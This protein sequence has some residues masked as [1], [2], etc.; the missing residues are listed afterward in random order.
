MALTRAEICERFR[1]RH[2]EKYTAEARRE[3]RKRYEA[4][5][6]ATPG[7]KK[8]REKYIASGKKALSDANSSLFYRFG[9]TLDDKL[10]QYD[11]QNGLCD[12]CGE[13]LPENPLKCHWDH[14]HKTGEMRS[15]LHP[16]CNVLVGA[17]EHE[18]HNKVIAYLEKHRG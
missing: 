11:K 2:P 7:Y 9:K 6:R 15:L 5:Y 16:Y 14:N 17:T 3:K 13:A 10:A 1:Q 4:K 12:L 18:L 8:A